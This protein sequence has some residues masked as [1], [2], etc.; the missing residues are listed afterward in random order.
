[1]DLYYLGTE[2][3]EGLSF[4]SFLQEDVLYCDEFSAITQLNYRNQLAAGYPL[5]PLNNDDINF[6]T[7][8]RD[9]QYPSGFQEPGPVDAQ[10]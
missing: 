2:E 8:R 3:N 4:D 1:M 5:P 9:E 7:R 6:E 10:A